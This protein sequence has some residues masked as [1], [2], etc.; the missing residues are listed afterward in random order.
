MT[1]FL[2]SQKPFE[3]INIAP[4]PVVLCF[5]QASSSATQPVSP[6]NYE[7]ST[8]LA[9]REIPKRRRPPQALFVN[10]GPQLS[11]QTTRPVGNELHSKISNS[12][13]VETW[14]AYYSINKA[15]QPIHHEWNKG[16]FLLMRV[17]KSRLNHSALRQL[18]Q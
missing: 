10:P 11:H 7:P 6:A 13:T 17:T 3:N 12:I 8:H 9:L 14:V 4:P 2:H 5:R 15:L 1:T 18:Y 16:F